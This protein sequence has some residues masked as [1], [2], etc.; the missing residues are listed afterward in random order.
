M[1]D[2]PPSGQYAYY[3]NSIAVR[4][5]ADASSP[6]E[7]W[8]ASKVVDSQKVAGLAPILRR[9]ADGGANWT[10]AAALPVPSAYSIPSVGSVTVD[11]SGRAFV[12]ASCSKKVGKTSESH[13]LIYR[14][15]NGGVS[16]TLV[17]DVAG[18]YDDNGGAVDAFNGIFFTG[19]GLTRASL[20]GGSTWV[21]VTAVAGG[22]CIAA[23][24]VG[25]VFAGGSV[26]SGSTT[27]GN[28]Y[29]LPVP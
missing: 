9:S 27:Y 10:T 23:D 25:N 29:K 5:S 3:A 7:I 13:A 11:W 19:A 28:I 17:D 21:T 20:D 1:D 16:W 4:P 14:S 8:V 15:T 22:S 6:S 26:T 18:S 12:S 24:R 2:Y